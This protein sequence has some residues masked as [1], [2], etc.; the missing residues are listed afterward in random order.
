MNY[1]RPRGFLAGFYSEVPEPASPELNHVGEQWAPRDFFIPWHTHTV[2]EFYL[3]ISGETHWDAPEPDYRLRPGHFM[4][5]PPGVRH[6]MHDL[7]EGRHHFYFAAIDLNRLLAEVPE[8]AAYWQ[9]TTTVFIPQADTLTGP[10]RQ[11]I[12]EVSLQMSHRAL[13]VR[14]ALQ[15][16]VVEATR[17]AEK[18]Q[19]DTS[20]VFRHPAV[21][22]AKE[23]LEHQAG[24]HWNL[25]DLAFRVGLSPGHLVECF[26]KDVGVSPHHYLLQIRVEQAKEW[27]RQTNLSITEMAL[28]LG[29]SSS[30][31][32]ATTFKRITGTSAQQYRNTCRRSSAFP[33]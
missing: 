25:T 27:L 6:Q 4:A 23:L 14:T 18:T 5:V 8:L 11:L 29:F 30:Q 13:G 24:H 17:L 7:P 15:Y 19:P 21:L 9:R 22:H 32:F 1:S 3:Q 33:V 31:H 28:E 26:T 20:L 2:W 12:R 10:F 16:L